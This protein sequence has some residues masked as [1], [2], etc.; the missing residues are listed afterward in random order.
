[1]ETLPQIP[2]VTVR[3]R[4]AIGGMGELFLVDRVGD[5][6]VAEVAVLK[7]LL[8][9]ADATHQALFAREGDVLAQLASPHIVRLLDRGPGWLLLEHVDGCD[10][11]TLLA[12]RA[13]RGRPLPLPAAWA[14]LGGLCEALADLHEAAAADGTPLGLVHRDVNP[15]NVLLTRDGAVKL[16]DLGVV[17][18]ALTDAATVAGVKGTLAYMAPE[19]LHGR[20]AGPAADLYAAGLVAYEVLTGVP[21]RPQG[22]AV[23]LAELLAARERLP[24]PPSRLRGK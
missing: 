5:D 16:I 18:T 4:L 2:G 15:A 21:A 7:R 19:Q 9:G 12:Q 22:A 20:A 24:A 14:L 17:R 13:R 3:R 1:M 23:G 11:A 10:L 6:G 8:P